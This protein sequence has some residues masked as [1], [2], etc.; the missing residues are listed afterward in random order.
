[1]NADQT[2]NSIVF[3][4]NFDTD[5]LSKRSSVA[6]GVSTPDVMTIRS[7]D[8]VDS[9]TKVPG[10]RH[11]V[12]LGRFELDANNVLVEQSIAFTIQTPQTA[13]SAGVTAQLATF[14]AMVAA[15][16]IMEAVINNEK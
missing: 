6:R 13:T 9:K 7:E 11:N 10:R 15:S 5:G 2:Y 12:R 4:K 16:G 1:M 3:V 14:R 8:Y